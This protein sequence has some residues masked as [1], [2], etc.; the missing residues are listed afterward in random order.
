MYLSAEAIV[1]SA[2]LC[3]TAI[4]VC[5]SIVPPQP[6]PSEKL[7]EKFNV[8]SPASNGEGYSTVASL[9]LEYKAAFFVSYFPYLFSTWVVCMNTLDILHTLDLLPHII[10]LADQTT[11]TGTINTQLI[12]GFILTIASTAFRFSAFQTMGKLFTYH[13]AIL[14]DHKLVTH[15][16][17][18]Y[19][20]HPS[21]TA[22][23]LIFVGVLL[24]TTAPGSV[25]YD[26]LGMDSTR[27]LMTALALAIVCGSY[28][29]VGRAEVED[30]VLRKEFGEE[31][32]EWARKVPY[33]FIPYLL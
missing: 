7:C 4:G 29:L 33:K 1:K 20:R 5:L 16:A 21:Y 18:A 6:K 14:P 9:W 10:P 19:C 2:W 32:V 8:S 3:V 17:Y 11:T 23:Q 31:W 13:L 28:E 24:T 15:G 22:L 27:K 30:R 26:H 25:L 12:I